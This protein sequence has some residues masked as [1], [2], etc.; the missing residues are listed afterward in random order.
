MPLASYLKA[1]GILRLLAMPSNNVHGKAA[2]PA[3][4]GWWARE[5]FHL[6][7]RLDHNALLRFFLEDYAASPI[8]SPWNGRAGFLEGEDN[9]DSTRSGAELVR[10]LQAADAPRFAPF[11]STVSILLESDSLKEL[12]SLRDQRKRRDA[13]KKT[14]GLSDEEIVALNALKR[15]EGVLKTRLIAE[16]RGTVSEQVVEWMDAC[17][18]VGAS[19]DAPQ[20]APLL[21]SGGN[22]GSRDLGVNFWQQ[23]ESLFDF[24][25]PDGKAR[26]AAASLL[27]LAI[28]GTATVDLKT[29][30]M[31][32]F[33]PGQAGPNAGVG[34]GDTAP[35][36]SWDTILSLEGSIMLAG[37]ATR[38]L[39]GARTESSF[40]FTV[41]STGAAGGGSALA[42]EAEA[43][44]EIWMPLWPNPAAYSEIVALFS[45]GRATLGRHPVRD[46]LGFARAV[47]TLGVNRGVSS[48]QRYGFMKREGRSYIAV[49]LTRVHVQRND[50]ADLLRDLDHRNWLQ[51]FRDYSRRKNAPARSQSIAEQLDE[52]IFAM[53]QEPSPR[54]VQR[55]LIAVGDVAAYL[56]SS[57]KARDPK[58]GRQ[59]PPPRLR[60]AWF[61]AADDGS[62]EFRIA[63][64]LAGL[65]RAQETADGAANAG[66]EADLDPADETEIGE[67]DERERDTDVAERAAPAE[68]QHGPAPPPPFRAHLAPLDEKTWYRRVRAWSERDGLAV[69][70]VGTLDRNLIAV[71]ER[72][73]IFSLQRKL[74]GG[75]F[76][77]HAPADLA[78]V[79]DFLWRDTDDAKIADLVHGFAWA[80]A[81]H[82]IPTE[83]AQSRPLPLAY[84][85]IKLFFA[86]ASDLRRIE[87]IPN[88]IRLP[89]PP[90]LV[91]R[92]R[93][94]NVGAAVSLACRRARASGL[95]ITFEP[96]REDIVDMDGARLLAAL[97]IPIRYVDL[98]RAMERAYPDLFE[99]KKTPQP[100]EDTTDAA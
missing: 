54:S 96:R 73:L 85:L 87:Q 6:K 83:A 67:T 42:D 79:L 63:A 91:A 22:D 21:G 88:D 13:R 14:S 72:R 52:A 37:A 43:R 38:R 64:A 94:G 17:W 98:R 35:L 55:L 60:P 40:P 59:R 97:L 84:A 26:P 93:V 3:A 11:K 31:G 75:P 5:H 56:A 41:G 69:W 46:G 16:L 76:D 25:S 8:V 62:A 49:P 45:E 7:T 20:P 77:R 19:D 81:P 24:H 50:K 30:A 28:F 82:F 34:F 58:G 92:L 78:S 4:R 9:D 71:A 10:S 33:A 65:G 61:Q 23:L 39:G 86:P 99:S 53:T 15:R 18:R 48:F 57:P 89:M 27:R 95:P 66:G 36:N 44:G 32:L 47:V 70:G 12:N 68:E 1:L 100:K 80:D 90:G 29:G 2:D 51:Q 74:D